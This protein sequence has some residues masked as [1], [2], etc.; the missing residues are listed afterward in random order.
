MAVE[1]DLVVLSDVVAAVCLLVRRHPT[2]VDDQERLVILVEHELGFESS[3]AD[4][5]EDEDEEE[6]AQAVSA[7]LTHGIEV[8]LSTVVDLLL[9]VK[10]ALVKG[11]TVHSSDDP[12][13]RLIG[14]QVSKA[15]GTPLSYAYVGLSHVK[16]SMRSPELKELGLEPNVVQSCLALPGGRASLVEMLKALVS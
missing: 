16:A 15:D 10:D 11:L 12:L 8:P 14:Y 3:E 5:D 2:L 6:D 13:R 7:D 1:P 9:F 4:E